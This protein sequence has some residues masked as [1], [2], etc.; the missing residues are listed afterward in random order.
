MAKLNILPVDYPSGRL[1]ELGDRLTD[2]FYPLIDDYAVL[3]ER[4]I[5]PYLLHIVGNSPY[6]MADY[7]LNYLCSPKA[8]TLGVTSFPID[9]KEHWVYGKGRKTGQACISTGYNGIRDLEF[10]SN[11]HF[12]AV[13]NIGIHEIGHV[14]DLGHHDFIPKST[15]SG[16]YC[17]M[18]TAHGRR[19]NQGQLLWDDY[20]AARDSSE[21]CVDC[22]TWLEKLELIRA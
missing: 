7:F 14:F 19:V 21:F 16:L 9:D 5:E 22:N 8:L 3:D 20:F 1:N 4:Q 6:L 15:S 13:L 11:I 10:N 2:V 12:E 17:P 18:T